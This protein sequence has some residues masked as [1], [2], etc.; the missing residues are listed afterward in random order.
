M[1]FT[2]KL[3][4]AYFFAKNFVII[5]GYGGEI[6][7]QDS[8]DY[9]ELTQQKFMHEISWVIIASGMNDKVVRKIFPLI[10][11]SMFDFQSS[12]SICDNK[13]KCFDNSIKILNH[14]G[15]INAILYVAEYIKKNSFKS[16]KENISREGISFIQ[17]F[18]YMGKATSFHLAKNIGLNFAKPDRHL[19]RI[20]SVLGYNDPHELCEVI[21]NSI[22]EKKSLVDLVL[23][24][25]STLD[26]NYIKNINWYIDRKH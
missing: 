19:V 26:K 3:I 21:S 8:I 18:P 9:E 15:K 17:T 12:D 5:K 20:S 13:Q 2:E 14:K 10:K 6:D 1:N 24:R 4:H 22:Q 16:L 7:W 23:W 25:Y 11:K